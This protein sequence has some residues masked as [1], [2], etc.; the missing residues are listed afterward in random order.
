[1]RKYISGII[2]GAL[3]MLGTSAFADEIKSVVGKAIQGQFDI[4]VDGKKLKNPV[5]VLDGTSYAPVREFGESIGYEVLFDTE[6]GVILNKIEEETSVSHLETL[7]TEDMLKLEYNRNLLKSTIER[8]ASNEATLESSRQYNEEAQLGVFE[9]RPIY[10]D[11]TAKIN[12]DK[13]EIIRITAEIEALEAQL[14][15]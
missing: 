2:I 15:P 5:I 11:L 6:G 10:A 8:L 7:S 12:A 1:M 3:L 4:T 14:Q 9:E 13:A